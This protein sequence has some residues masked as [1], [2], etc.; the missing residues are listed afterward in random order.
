VT[1]GASPDV[2]AAVDAARII[3]F[4]IREG[5]EAGRDSAWDLPATEEKMDATA[6]PLI[7][8]ITLT[9][10]TLDGLISAAGNDAAAAPQPGGFGARRDTPF[11]PQS[12]ASGDPKPTSVV[13]WTRVVDGE[14]PVERVLTLEVARNDR[15]QPGDLVVRTEVVALAEHDGCVRVKIT[16]LEPDTFYYY[17]FLYQRDETVSTNIG[18]TKTAPQASAERPV[19]FAFA[20]CQDF[21]ERYYN[22]Y[23]PLLTEDARQTIDFIV[24]LGDFIYETTRDRDLSPGESAR[25]I[26]FR[27]EAGALDLSAITGDSFA[28]RSLDN[29][30]QLYQTYRSDIVLQAVLESY[31]LITTWDDH[32][33]SD[34]SWQDHATY[35]NDR[36]PD[37]EKDP[38]RKR[39]AERAWL[40]YIPVDLDDGSPAIMQSVV[41]TGAPGLPPKIYRA[42]RF[43]NLLQI[44]LTDY[45][46]FR[47][48]HLVE[49]GAFPGTIFATEQQ[50]R[51]AL[52]DEAFERVFLE[53]GRRSLFARFRPVVRWESLSFVQRLIL[54]Q[55]IAREYREAGYLGDPQARAAEVLSGDLDADYLNLRL[56]LFPFLRIATDRLPRGLA[57]GNLNKLALFSGVGARF[58]S[59]FDVFEVFVSTLRQR[60]EGSQDAYGPEQETFLREALGSGSSGG[61]ALWKMVANSVSS[62][63]MIVDV[64]QENLDAHLGP[65]S[66]FPLLSLIA[67]VIKRTPLARRYAIR[68][69]QWDGLPDKRE[70]LLEF[71][72]GLGGDSTVVLIAGD[73]HASFVANHSSPAGRVFEFTGPAIS[74]MTLVGELQSFFRGL[75]SS[76]ASGASAEDVL[77]RL[78]AANGLGDLLNGIRM[79]GDR[80]RLPGIPELPELSLSAL[81][82]EIAR[83]FD[84]FLIDKTPRSPFRPT[85][86]AMRIEDA[87]TDRHGIVVVDVTD[88]H[89]EA[90]YFLIEPSLVSAPLYEP[91]QPDA[92]ERAVD[93]YFALPVGPRG[94]GGLRQI[95]RFQ[96][97]RN[98]AEGGIERVDDSL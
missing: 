49:E 90:S 68:L 65:G 12:L 25:R 91:T 9:A 50:L 47:P 18:R 32:E 14:A 97:S 56:L 24:H 44:I 94:E 40:E 34:D 86:E 58:G 89:C 80:L 59:D 85:L 69:D 67:E 4:N 92:I 73:I 11:F 48:D 83:A 23:L 15:F 76:V 96:V 79:I 77:A 52:G 2:K 55:I 27:D 36:D 54:S 70:E 98:G 84:S 8:T 63:A 33:F 17:R 46:T 21:I 45:R 60:G 37:L 31:P 19:R 95:K 53:G 13:L 87:D 7:E 30:R 88:Q 26:R 64:T 6:T 72:R 74:T 62:T 42:F 35:L 1:S 81:L 57:I 29:Y 41:H 51:G 66:G 43:G 3:R 20:S 5:V 78:G 61:G 38:E 10:G 22:A 75:G 82:E 93:A 39:N 71:Y 16:G 28:A